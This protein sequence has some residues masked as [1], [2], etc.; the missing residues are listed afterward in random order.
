MPRLKPET[1]AARKAHILEAALTRFSQTGYHQ[2]TMDD[3]VQ[4]A[5]LSK[6]SIYTYFESKKGLF[7]AL[8]EKMLADSGLL[9]ILSEDSLSGLERLNSAL[10][11]MIA[12]T[13]SEAYK[14]YAALLM[15]AWTLSQIDADVKQACTVVYEQLRQSFMQLIEQSIARGEFKAVDAS[16][17]ASIFIAVFDGLMVQVMIDGTAIDWHTASEAISHSWMYGLLTND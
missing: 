7:L 5:G 16:S 4:E 1:L 11:E 3:V 13:T 14:D 9:P 12:F 10:A 2:T 15:E 17:L 6:G 8:L